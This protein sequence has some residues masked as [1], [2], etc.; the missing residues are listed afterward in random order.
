MSFR[1]PCSVGS[2]IRLKTVAVLASAALGLTSCARSPSAQHDCEH[3][4]EVVHRGQSSQADESAWA[5]LPEC[6]VAGGRAAADAWN[7]LRSVSDTGRIVK[8][9]GRL[10]GFR[11]SSL[12]GASRALLLDGAASAESR[13]FSA[14]LL[15]T[16]LVE[17]A[18]PDYRVYSTTGPH[19]VCTIGSTTGRSIHTV[20]PL[21]SNAGEQAQST[22][23]RVMTSEA[24]PASVRNAARCMYDALRR[25]EPVYALTASTSGGGTH[26]TESSGRVDTA[27]VRP[28][29]DT[30]ARAR[31]KHRPR[32]ATAGDT[33]RGITHLARTGACRWRDGSRVHDGVLRKNPRGD[34]LETHDGRRLPV[35]NLPR[36]LDDADGVRVWI[37]EPLGAPASAGIVDSDQPTDCPR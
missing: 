23:L 28:A 27:H 7:A 10:R 13:V 12:F 31:P 34:V 22:A 14:M 4:I 3:A 30:R 35:A 11:D 36:A 20:T 33:A 1:A 9:Y 21:P 5:T 18:D 25:D 29:A 19:D 6:G 24:D 26:V 37:A 15:V 16:Q 2:E 17:H 8:T 32:L